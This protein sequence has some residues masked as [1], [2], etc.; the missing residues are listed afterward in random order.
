MLDQLLD[1][2]KGQVIGAITEKT[3]LGA[4]QAESA[5]PLAKESITSGLTEAVSG[6]DISGIMGMFSGGGDMANNGVF[7]SISNN[8]VGSL[9]SKLGVPESMAGMVSSAALPMIMDKIKGSASNDSGEVT[10]DGIMGLL[11]GSDSMIDMVKDKAMDAV[12][13]KLG[14]LGNLLG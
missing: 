3:G 13:D 4:D 11:G 14:G 9:V 1:A 6:G 5:F 8:F 7:S 2:A 10:Q 12:K